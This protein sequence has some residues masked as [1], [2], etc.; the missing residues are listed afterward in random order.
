LGRVWS[1]LFEH[2]L[3][4]GFG[5]GLLAILGNV[6]AGAYVF[7]ITK[8]DPKFGPYIDWLDTPHSRSFWALVAV[9]VLTGLYAWGIARFESRV[10]NALTNAE[11]R[12]RAIEELLPVVLQK[13]K[14]DVL[15]GRVTDLDTL[16]SRV[17]I[18]HRR[19]P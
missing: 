16:M 8:T 1:A 5:V 2:P 17:E 4:K 9:A 19:R 15:A 3:G 12:Q 13:A 18:D 6:L 10:R 11:L 14:E 7:E